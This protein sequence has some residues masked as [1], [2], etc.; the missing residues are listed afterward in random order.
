MYFEG[1]ALGLLCYG[2]DVLFF[3]FVYFDLLRRV[4]GWGWIGFIRCG[5]I[6]SIGGLLVSWSGGG[7]GVDARIMILGVGGVGS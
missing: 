2:F 6:L 1:L 7:L 5:G 4:W 3:R